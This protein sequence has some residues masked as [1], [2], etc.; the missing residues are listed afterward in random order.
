MEWYRPVH[1]KSVSSQEI[2]ALLGARK[3]LQSKVTLGYGVGLSTLLSD[4]SSLVGYRFYSQT[5]A[6][7]VSQTFVGLGVIHIVG[8]RLSIGAG[9]GVGFDRSTPSF[10]HFLSLSTLFRFLN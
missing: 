10:R 8:T 2:R 9:G 5:M 7:R 1:R 3:Q 4:T 6:R